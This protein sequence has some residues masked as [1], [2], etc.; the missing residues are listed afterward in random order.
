MSLLEQQ[1]TGGSKELSQS[2]QQTVAD[3]QTQQ[4]VSTV[5]RDTAQKLTYVGGDDADV[6]PRRQ[7]TWAELEQTTMQQ[8]TMQSHP[9]RHTSIPIISCKL[10]KS[11]TGDVL[12]DQMVEQK[13]TK[14]AQAIKG[15]NTDFNRAVHDDLGCAPTCIQSDDDGTN[16][17]LAAAFAPPTC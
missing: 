7:M 2:F 3:T 11:T 14:A 16:P 5:G 9:T 6:Q 1:F 15:N 12:L 13:V 17:E 4:S 8:D 10:T